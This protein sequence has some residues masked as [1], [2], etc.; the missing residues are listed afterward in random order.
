MAN[1]QLVQ[2]IAQYA[3]P[4]HAQLVMLGINCLMDFVLLF[5][6]AIARHV[7]TQKH[8]HCVNL[9]IF[10]HQELVNHA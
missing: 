10:Y 4:L 1:A 6:Q 3:L 9:D 2:L 8:A 5:V 7:V